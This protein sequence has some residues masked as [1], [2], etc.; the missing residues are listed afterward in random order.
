M[1]V[2]RLINNSQITDYL[3]IE[4]LIFKISGSLNIVQ[5]QVSWRDTYPQLMHIYAQKNSAHVSG[6][7][8]FCR[9][10]LMS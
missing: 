7:F 6:I 4:L 2:W 10:E 3:L 9:I 5:T 8:P 1:A